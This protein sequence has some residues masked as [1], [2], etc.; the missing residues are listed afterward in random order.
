KTAEGGGNADCQRKPPAARAEPP[1]ARAARAK[2]RRQRPPGSGACRRAA[3]RDRGVDREWGQG[4]RLGRSD[5][6]AE[7]PSS[8][9][10]FP[11]PRSRIYSGSNSILREQSA[12]SMTSL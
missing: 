12:Y 11:H 5:L 8:S 10:P 2:G 7:E 1:I 6:T 9:P 3:G 4:P